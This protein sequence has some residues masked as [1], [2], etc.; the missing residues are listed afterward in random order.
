MQAGRGGP[1][2]PET[3]AGPPQPIAALLGQ[4]A[5][6]AALVAAWL[7]WRDDAAWL[8]DHSGCVRARLAPELAPERAPAR[9]VAAWTRLGPSGELELLSWTALE[10]EPPGGQAAWL[11]GS[12]AALDEAYVG[13]AVAFDIETIPAGPAAALPERIAARLERHARA[14]L[15]RDG[16]A[17]SAERMAERMDFEQALNPLL[18]R[19]VSL[20]LVDEQETAPAVWLVAPQ[21]AGDAA[22]SRAGAAWRTLASERDLCRRFWHMALLC[23]RLVSFHGRGFDLPYIEARSRV[24]G[25]APP[26]AGALPHDDLVDLLPL[27]RGRHLGSLDLACLAF[28]IP[29]PKTEHSGADVAMLYKEGR[30]EEL[31]RYNLADARAT[32]ELWRR[33]RRGAALL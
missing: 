5:G 6:S 18:G 15:S 30:L 19:I 33:L 8:I 12:D 21:A 3:P 1:A 7:A 14:A 9:P 32:L 22:A 10:Q 17:P 28:G 13:R 26:R 29:S 27:P 16:E 20:A 31:A 25:L 11:L 24:A 4:A 23:R 2:M